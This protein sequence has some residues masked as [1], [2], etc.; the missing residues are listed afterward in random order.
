[1]VIESNKGLIEK[2][3]TDA[4][5]VATVHKELVGIDGTKVRA[6]ATKLG[7]ED[8]VSLNINYTPGIS[9]ST[10]S[11]LYLYPTS[12]TSSIT[13]APNTLKI[14]VDVNPK[15]ASFNVIE[16]TPKPEQI[17]DDSLS[18][19]FTRVEEGTTNYEIRNKEDLVNTFDLTGVSID[20]LVPDISS[21]TNDEVIIQFYPVPENFPLYTNNPVLS[22]KHLT[23]GSPIWKV[24]EGYAICIIPV[25]GQTITEEGT[26]IIQGS[27]VM[28]SDLSSS[29]SQYYIASI[30]HTA[31]ISP[32]YVTSLQTEQPDMYMSISSEPYSVKCNIVPS[33]ATIQ[34]LQW[35]TTND[36]VKLQVAPT[37]LEAKVI[38]TGVVGNSIVSIYSKD[39]DIVSTT[40]NVCIYDLDVH[41]SETANLGDTVIIDVE[42]SNEEFDLSLCETS[43][44]TLYGRATATS[45]N[46]LPAVTINR[47]GKEVVIVTVKVPH[48]KGG[49]DYEIF[50]FRKEFICVRTYDFVAL[51]DKE[52]YHSGDMVTI[53]CTLKDI[54]GILLDNVS[55]QCLPYNNEDTHNC[56]ITVNGRVIFNYIVNDILVDKY[57]LNKHKLK[58]VM[59][60]TPSVFYEYDVVYSKKE[61]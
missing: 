41:I 2:K 27:F 49:T 8:S 20:M 51:F 60:E 32:L 4:R 21:E 28:Q 40:L 45:V 44:R 42:S 9:I 48:F 34:D 31:N 15:D 16:W 14:D 5:G 7:V 58:I 38:Q 37:T 6:V 33:E 47:E 22:A 23:F 30:E 13:L 50:E 1:M 35:Q 61:N 55:M 10:S 11:N 36:L 54:S 57:L 3:N 43:I 46:G 25:R 19:I 56:R 59:L 18:A 24:E 12:L 17:L 26:T 29:P 52:E 53:D 39:A